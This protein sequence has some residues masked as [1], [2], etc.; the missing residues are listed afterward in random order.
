M[1]SHG[2]VDLGGKVTEAT[3]AHACPAGYYA[4]EKHEF[5]SGFYVKCKDL[6]PLADNWR[7]ASLT[8]YCGKRLCN[9]DFNKV[10]SVWHPKAHE[11]AACPLGYYESRKYQVGSFFKDMVRE[12]IKQNADAWNESKTANSNTR[13]VYTMPSFGVKTT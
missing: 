6:F 3:D 1:N 5:S 8:L 7:G 4:A 9:G 13:G 12:C 11:L 2:Q 10:E